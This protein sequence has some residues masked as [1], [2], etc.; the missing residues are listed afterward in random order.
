M[1]VLNSLDLLIFGDGGCMLNANGAAW[2]A[3]AV[4]AVAWG[5]K[6]SGQ[7]V[8]AW[9]R[10]MRRNHGI[11]GGIVLWTYGTG[12]MPCINSCN[13]DLAVAGDYL[14]AV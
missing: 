6:V 10:E 12:F 8:R 11:H 14:W 7:R 13:T 5:A 9:L 1:W 3:V 4:C 2:L